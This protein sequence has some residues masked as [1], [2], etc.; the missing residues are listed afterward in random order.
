MAEFI[1][2]DRFFHIFL[3][4]DAHIPINHK[5][6]MITE[7]S[8]S[9]N[10]LVLHIIYYLLIVNTKANENCYYYWQNLLKFTDKEVNHLRILGGT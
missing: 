2:N 6:F 7:F 9:R 3:E 10:A 4:F 8:K 5:T 1:K